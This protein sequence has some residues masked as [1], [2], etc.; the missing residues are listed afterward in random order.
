MTLN[1]YVPNVAVRNAAKEVNSVLKLVVFQH[2]LQQS[3]LRPI[4]PNDPTNMWVRRTHCW[5]DIQEQVD[6][7]SVRES[8]DDHNVDRGWLRS[9]CQVGGE[10]CGIHGVR[11]NRDVYRVP[12]SAQHEILLAG[13]GHRYCVIHVRHVELQNFVEVDGRR[14]VKTKKGMIRVHRP[15]A[16]GACVEQ[17]LVGQRR[18]RLMPVHDV[19]SFP[20]VNISHQRKEREEGWKSGVGHECQVRQIVDLETICHVANTL[21]SVA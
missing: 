9:S 8:A 21:P 5:Y 11:D 15:Q 6:A 4:A 7:L 19:D 1:Q 17:A 18:R 20:Y 10:S 13:I 2:F 16:H 12:R 14:V 3:P